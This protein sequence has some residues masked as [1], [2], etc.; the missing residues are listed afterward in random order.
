VLRRCPRP[1]GSARAD[2][3]VGP[4][5]LFINLLKVPISTTQRAQL[6]GLFQ[7]VALRPWPSPAVTV[8]AFPP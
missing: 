2:L 4:T 5:T 8:L 1:A 3:K 7:R 6:M